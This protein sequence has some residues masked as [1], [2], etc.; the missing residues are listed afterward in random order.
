[1]KAYLFTH[2]GTNSKARHNNVRVARQRGAATR[3]GN[4]T[5][6]TGVSMLPCREAGT[7]TAEKFDFILI[8]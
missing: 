6:E 4:G 1:M 5:P 8:F 3:A 2:A 7:R